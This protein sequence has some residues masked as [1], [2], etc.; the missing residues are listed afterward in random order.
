MSG[1]GEITIRAARPG[2]AGVVDLAVTRDPMQTQAQNAPMTNMANSMA[3]QAASP[4]RQAQTA[5]G[6]NN[7]G[8]GPGAPQKRPKAA[9]AGAR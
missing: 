4:M 5:P 3:T 2:E 7:A 1:A 8:K 6:A 9:G